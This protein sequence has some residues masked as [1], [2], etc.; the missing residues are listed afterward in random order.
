V[1]SMFRAFPDE[2][3]AHEHQQCRSAAVM[4]R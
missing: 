3:L 4:A 2:V 1:R